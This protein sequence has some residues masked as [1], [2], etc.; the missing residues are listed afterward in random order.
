VIMVVLLVQV[1]PRERSGADTME[2]NADLHC[3]DVNAGC[4]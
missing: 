1:A 2:V 3:V 4:M